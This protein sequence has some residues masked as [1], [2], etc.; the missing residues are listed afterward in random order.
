MSNLEHLFYGD[1]DTSSEGLTVYFEDEL[2][3]GTDDE[4]EE[5]NANDDYINV[6]EGN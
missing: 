4:V 6:I 5:A 3:D 1:S 2:E